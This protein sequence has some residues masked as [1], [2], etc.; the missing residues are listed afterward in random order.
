[1]MKAPYLLSRTSL[2]G[3][4]SVVCAELPQTTSLLALQCLYEFRG[5][6]TTDHC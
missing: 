4:V 5:T 3:H 1:M 2:Q 6:S